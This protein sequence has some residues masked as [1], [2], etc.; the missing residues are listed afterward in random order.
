VRMNLLEYRGP[1][2]FKSIKRY[3]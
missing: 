2:F 3:F 1:I